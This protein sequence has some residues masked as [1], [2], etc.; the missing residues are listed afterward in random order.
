MCHI[1]NL[2][3]KRSEEGDR[4][5]AEVTDSFESPCVWMQG[6]LQEQ[7]ELF[8]P[9]SFLQPQYFNVIFH[10]PVVNSMK[11]KSTIR[12]LTWLFHDITRISSAASQIHFCTFVLSLDCTYIHFCLDLRFVFILPV[13]LVDLFDFFQE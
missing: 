2:G 1:C 12:T 11:N 3:P 10:N 7:Q 4:Y 8:T 6:L 13:T 9:K 5:G